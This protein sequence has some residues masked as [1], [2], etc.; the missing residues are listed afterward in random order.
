MGGAGTECDSDRARARR[1]TMQSR[2]VM[3][4]DRVRFQDVGHCSQHGSGTIVSIIA[5]GN[6]TITCSQ[7]LWRRLSGFRTRKATTNGEWGYGTHEGCS[8]RLHPQV[9]AVHCSIGTKVVGVCSAVH[10]ALR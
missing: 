7:T 1:T 9:V 8:W 2:R 3:G 10:A 5:Y 6:I 4:F